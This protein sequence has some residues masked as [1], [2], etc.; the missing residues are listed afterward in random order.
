MTCA[1]SSTP[2]V[3]TL[4]TRSHPCPAVFL[5]LADLSLALCTHRPHKISTQSSPTSRTGCTTRARTSPSKARAQVSWRCCVEL[6]LL[7]LAA[8][9]DKLKSMTVLSDPALLRV[10]EHEKL[11]AAENALRQ[12]IVHYRKFLSEH[13]AGSDKYA[14]IDAAD[15][16]KVCAL[17]CCR[18]CLIQQ[19][20]RVSIIHRS[21][22]LLRSRRSLWTRRCL[23]S[24]PSR[25]ASLLL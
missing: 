2:L 7:V 11:P 16:A 20:S 5:H 1:T 24:A 23:P 13:A 6:T 3:N 19:F 4:T 21:Q 25:R 22:P 15:V 10:K 9:T 18:V 17:K 14:H 8:Y 12:A